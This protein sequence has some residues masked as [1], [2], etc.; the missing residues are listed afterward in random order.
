MADR[1]QEPW[2]SRS[3]G[4]AFVGVLFIGLAVGMISGQVAGFAMLGLGVAFLATALVGGARGRSGAGLLFSGSLFTGIGLGLLLGNAAIGVLL[5]LGVGFL[6][7][8]LAQRA[9]DEPRAPSSP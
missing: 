4:L 1:A 5:G 7:M 8:A 2:R 3:G 9:G 6:L